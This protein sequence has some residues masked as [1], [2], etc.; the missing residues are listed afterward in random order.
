M[1]SGTVGLKDQSK[2]LTEHLH[3]AS[4]LAIESLKLLSLTISKNEPEH[5]S[6]IPRRWEQIKQLK[7]ITR[8]NCEQILLR[9]QPM[10]RGLRTILAS[11]TLIEELENLVFLCHNI[12]HAIDQDQFTTCPLPPGNFEQL[13]SSLS[14]LLNETVQLF[15][16]DDYE[17]DSN[18]ISILTGKLTFTLRLTLEIKSDYRTLLQRHPEQYQQGINFLLITQ[19]L[20]FICEIIKH[21]VDLSTYKNFGWFDKENQ[22]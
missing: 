19:N 9:W 2:E 16:R 20:E 11:L 4:I 17:R 6:Q 5:V 7:M 22:Q 10:A 14:T 18:T 15:L 8:K 21:V 12:G 3:G 1:L 13:F